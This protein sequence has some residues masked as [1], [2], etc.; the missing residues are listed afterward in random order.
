MGNKFS[1]K[2]KFEAFTFINESEA[3]LTNLR[4]MLTQTIPDEDIKLGIL[5]NVI[6]KYIQENYEGFRTTFVECINHVF[7]V[8]GSEKTLGD[9]EI[10]Y[11]NNTL[12]FL[13]RFLPI[14]HEQD[15]KERATELLW[16]KAEIPQDKAAELKS[17]QPY[18]ME[19]CLAIKLLTSLFKLMFL[20]NYSIALKKSTSNDKETKVNIGLPADS[21]LFWKNYDGTGHPNDQ[22]K[23]YYNR[24]KVL[25]CLLACFSTPLLYPMN[26][27]ERF[28][29]PWIQFCISHHNPLLGSAVISMLNFG[30]SYEE[31]GKLPYT[32]YLSV[33]TTGEKLALLSLQIVCLFADI[34]I[35]DATLYN[36]VLEN[37][38]YQQILEHY[39]K[40]KDQKMTVDVNEI[41]N[42]VNSKE[43]LQNGCLKFF[44]EL[45]H[46]EYYKFFIN[47]TLR[48]LRNPYDAENTFLIESRKKT[49]LLEEILI[50]FWRLVEVNHT[51]LKVLFYTEEFLQIIVYLLYQMHESFTFALRSHIFYIAIIIL[52][53]LSCDRFFAVQLKKKYRND[54]GFTKIPI[55]IGNHIDLI[56][57]VFLNGM[58]DS[59]VKSYFCYQNNLLSILHNIAPFAKNLSPI[60]TSLLI[61]AVK[62]T[63]NPKVLKADRQNL[64]N[65]RKTLNLIHKIVCY[66]PETCSNLLYELLAQKSELEL[67]RKLPLKRI[68]GLPGASRLDQSSKLGD[69]VQVNASARNQEESKGPQEQPGN[70]SPAKGGA[71]TSNPEI[72]EEGEERKEV[73]RPVTA[74]VRSPNKSDG[75]PIQLFDAK[76]MEIYAHNL[77]FDMIFLVIGHLQDELTN[78]FKGKPTNSEEEVKEFLDNTSILGIV[79]QP[80]P[81]TIEVVNDP[82]NINNNLFLFLWQQ[83]F[84]KNQGMPYFD[85]QDVKLLNVS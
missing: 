23:F 37:I 2:E 79:P 41:R 35:D 31:N 40:V 13:V 49:V 3:T 62:A 69:S 71:A 8:A 76:W 67:L 46:T 18:L 9:P 52:S 20:P 75:E 14:L 61:Q 45:K 12:M 57:V 73:Q 55:F 47:Q 82:L 22:Y 4:E 43:I 80:G 54:I 66:Q 19:E 7:T 28:G 5:P 25:E 6:R 64:L 44:I 34:R 26:S 21:R 48:V 74:Q 32:Q 36:R 84:W 29:D 59:Y 77:S 1:I 53:K 81:I 65:L 42:T 33:D 17:L 72:K 58:V 70:A 39:I 30:L 15:F 50:L 68:Y 56:F 27:K 78:V 38:E 16:Q 85:T 63:A 60:T 51:F 10:L 11:L 24:M 83:I